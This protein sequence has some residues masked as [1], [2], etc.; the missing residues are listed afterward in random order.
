MKRSFT[1]LLLKTIAGCLL[2]IA[3]GLI[4]FSVSNLKFFSNESDFANEVKKD[5]W[6]IAERV[7]GSYTEGFDKSWALSIIRTLDAKVM[8]RDSF[9][10]DNKDKL[11]LAY[12][13]KA[14]LTRP[15]YSDP[16][17]KREVDYRIEILFKFI[18]EEGLVLGYAY[19]KSCPQYEHEKFPTHLCH[20]WDDPLSK[21]VIVKGQMSNVTGATIAKKIAR[22]TYEPSIEMDDWKT[23]I[24]SL[25]T[26]YEIKQ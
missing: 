26:R 18:D 2:L 21:D 20:R 10:E 22:I 17:D 19:M 13:V 16:S 23:Y 9:I 8:L 11:D 25:R 15:I 5:R 12:E 24:D 6:V 1:N 4:Y 3:T 14:K 7:P